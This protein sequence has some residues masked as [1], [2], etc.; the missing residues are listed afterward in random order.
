MKA[1]KNESVKVALRLRP[2]NKREE[3]LGS[4]LCVYSKDNILTIKKAADA[5]DFVFDY[6]FGID[7]RQE[8]IYE[9]CAYSIVENALEGFN[10]TMFAYGQTGAGKT[11]TMVGD[12]KDPHLKGIIPRGFDHVITAI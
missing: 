3:D 7:T 8:N 12:Y 9:A 2:L 10:G 4:P 1:E 5:K 11:F 6:V